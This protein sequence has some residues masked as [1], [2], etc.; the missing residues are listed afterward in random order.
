MATTGTRKR[1]GD[2]RRRDLCDA[3]IRVLAEDGSRGLTHGQVDRV[4]GVPE[5]TTSY[6]Y[7][8][9]VALLRGVGKRV[10]E[11][12]VANLQSVIDDDRPDTD[13]SALPLESRSRRQRERVRAAGQTDEN[14]IALRHR[15]GGEGLAHGTA[16]VGDGGRQT[17]AA[18]VFGHVTTVDAGLPADCIG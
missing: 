6:Y 5:G 3:A 10:A 11:I 14:E 16:H 9:R 12:D 7:R 15:C 17:R 4:A 2:E 13:A 18:D 8:T 1:N